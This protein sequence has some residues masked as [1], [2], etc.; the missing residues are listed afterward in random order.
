MKKTISI[1]K[2]MSDHK[3]L[4]EEIDMKEFKLKKP[5]EMVELFNGS[6]IKDLSVIKPAID[7]IDKL[8]QKLL[9]YQLLIDCIRHDLESKDVKIKL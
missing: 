3:Q 2:V 5:S 1:K 9:D 7:Y 8:Q 6:G 4:M